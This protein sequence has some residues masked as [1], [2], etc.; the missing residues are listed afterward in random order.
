MTPPKI[1]DKKPAVLELDPGKYYWCT[2]GTSL[3]QPFCDGSHKGSDFKPMLV[4]LTEK[5]KVALC[6]CKQTK[7]PPFCDGAHTK[8]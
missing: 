5:K 7:N 3:K 6:Q 1:A 8:L 2:C 4:E